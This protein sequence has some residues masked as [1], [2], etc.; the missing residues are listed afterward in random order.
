MFLA[1]WKGARFRAA[2]VRGRLARMQQRDL[3]RER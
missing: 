2:W 1:L 3:L